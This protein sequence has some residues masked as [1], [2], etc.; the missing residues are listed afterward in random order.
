MIEDENKIFEIYNI[1]VI[2]YVMVTVQPAEVELW[3]VSC[4]IQMNW[5][6]VL[7]LTWIWG[8]KNS[9]VY[10]INELI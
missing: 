9:L 10:F 7:L 3:Y 4:G 5:L 8:N 6:D 1:C 2:V